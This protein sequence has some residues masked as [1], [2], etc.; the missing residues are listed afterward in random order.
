MR[1]KIGDMH[2]YA[3]GRPAPDGAH[4]IRR[5]RPDLRA[6]ARYSNV[7]RTAVAGIPPTLSESITSPRPASDR[8]TTMLY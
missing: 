2:N 1:L 6:A 4:P 3:H 5:R 7:R 8:G